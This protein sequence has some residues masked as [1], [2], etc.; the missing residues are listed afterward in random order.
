MK[1]PYLFVYGTLMSGYGNNRLLQRSAFVGRAKTATPMLMTSSTGY[2]PRVFD[3]AKHPAAVRVSGEVWKVSR[4]SWPSIDMLEGYRGPGPGNNYDRVLT[5][6]VMDDGW[7]LEAYIYLGGDYG[8]DSRVVESG[9][10]RECREWRS[11]VVGHPSMARKRRP[12]RYRRVQR[13]ADEDLLDFYRRRYGWGDGG[14][15]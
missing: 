1:T 3:D 11:P 14:K 10:F 4:H 15:N 6:V 2:V 13:R 5:C 9:D 8:R 7:E 12:N